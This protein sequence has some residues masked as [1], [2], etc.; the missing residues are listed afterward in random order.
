MGE[1]CR[2]GFLLRAWASPR[3]AVQTES[4][5]G[6]RV[7]GGCWRWGDRGANGG[8]GSGNVGGP[9]GFPVHSSGFRPLPSTQG[10]LRAEE[11]FPAW[12]G[13][14]GG[15]GRTCAPGCTFAT[16]LF[17]LICGSWLQVLN[18]RRTG[19]GLAAPSP[20][21]PIP[22]PGLSNPHPFLSLLPFSLF[23][24]PSPDPRSPRNNGGECG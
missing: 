24:P 16:R 10:L 5:G 21:P 2:V 17:A 19:S 7:P 6:C 14:G 15:S 3:G 8:T 23:A 1:E 22:P 4:W 18:P 13:L 9:L 20:L 11:L 12:L